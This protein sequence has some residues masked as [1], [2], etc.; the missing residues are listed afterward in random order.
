MKLVTHNRHESGNCLKGLRSEV[1]GQ[2]R[3]QT[4]CYIGG[5]MHFD[6]VAL[7]LACYKV[8]LGCLSAKLQVVVYCCCCCRCCCCCCWW[9]WWWLTSRVPGLK[10]CDCVQAWNVWVW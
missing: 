2:G 10:L 3:D 5:G 8:M 7:R 4:E 1:K 9:W 6:S